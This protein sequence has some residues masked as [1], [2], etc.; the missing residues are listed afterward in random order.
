MINSLFSYYD[1][2]IPEDDLKIYEFIF[3]QSGL[4]KFKSDN[5][6]TLS[7]NNIVDSFIDNWVEMTAETDQYQLTTSSSS[8]NKC[9]RLLY[10]SF[11]GEYDYFYKQYCN[12][13]HSIIGTTDVKKELKQI[14]DWSK[15]HKLNSNSVDSTYS[16]NLKILNNS[17][18]STNSYI[19]KAL[20]EENFSN[21]KI[22]YNAIDSIFC[23]N[24]ILR[25]NK[26]PTS[27][28]YRFSKYTYSHLIKYL[29]TFIGLD[30]KDPTTNYLLEKLFNINSLAKIN[31]CY[32]L[33]MKTLDIS[34]TYA[35]KTIE[36]FVGKSH[37]ERV[38]DSLV[39]ILT[40]VCLS[41]GVYNRF[42]IMEIIYDDFVDSALAIGLNWH[43]QWNR[44]F[45][46]QEYICVLLTLIYNILLNKKI[47]ITND[48][49]MFLP[50]FAYNKDEIIPMI[51]SDSNLDV[52]HKISNKIFFDKTNLYPSLKKIHLIETFQNNLR[53]SII[54]TAEHSGTQYDNLF[55][56]L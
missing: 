55:F 27:E 12:T 3:E 22:Q 20:Y 6:E 51:N 18:H 43:S 1:E 48:E 4:Y 7:T 50:I 25:L 24:I 8:F 29:N 23:M 21:D 38:L 36:S 47:V 42:E 16:R 33:Y 56:S 45:K 49:K 2:K 31:E 40:N 10:Q 39:D 13:D 15:T 26:L 28:C 46:E 52:T 44:L 14:I 54:N 35:D 5:K 53:N 19:L 9:R 37:E 32:N 34:K 17:I 11:L 30:L 41:Y